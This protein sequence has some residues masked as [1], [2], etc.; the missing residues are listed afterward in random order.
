[1]DKGGEGASGVEGRRGRR[2][3]RGR[4]SK[5]GHENERRGVTP[6]PVLPVS[7]PSGGRCPPAWKPFRHIPERRRAGTE[8]ETAV[9][10]PA[11]IAKHHERRS[12][13]RPLLSEVALLEFPWKVA[14][15]HGRGRRRLV[16]GR[17][18]DDGSS[19]GWKILQASEIT[20]D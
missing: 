2:D 5:D 1:M 11:A 4:S 18:A 15:I 14:A 8:G 17:S 16:T 19:G 10:L 9:P 3:G 6:P 13:E 20:A 7:L 12:F